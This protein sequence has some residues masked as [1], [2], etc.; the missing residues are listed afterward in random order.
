[1]W[2]SDE[3]TERWPPRTLPK[4]SG[5]SQQTLVGLLGGTA[6]QSGADEEGAGLGDGS[7]HQGPGHR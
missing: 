2:W 7:G 6:G 3:V 4:S 5:H 1:M